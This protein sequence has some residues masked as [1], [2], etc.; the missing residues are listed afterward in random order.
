[1]NVVLGVRMF[2]TFRAVC[3]ARL[4]PQCAGRFMPHV[5][6]KAAGCIRPTRLMLWPPTHFP[7][8]TN[9]VTFG[10]T[11]GLPLPIQSY[12]LQTVHL[13]MAIHCPQQNQIASY[14]FAL[15]ARQGLP[16]VVDGRAEM[17]GAWAEEKRRY[18]FSHSQPTKKEKNA[19][20]SL[21][22]VILAIC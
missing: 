19:C 18:S 22:M 11:D 20:H 21:H 6:H 12:S 7:L 14:T 4:T 2:F 1:M 8:V 5:K 17:H 13:S 15:A 9:F 10:D 3:P 16:W